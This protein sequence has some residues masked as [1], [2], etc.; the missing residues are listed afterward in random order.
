MQETL[1]WMRGHH[2]SL[3]AM[4]E[5]LGWMRGHHRR[6]AVKEDALAWMRAQQGAMGHQIEELVS[7]MTGEPA[8]LVQT[9]HLQ[10][11]KGSRAY[12]LPATLKRDLH[13]AEL[14]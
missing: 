1:A 2:G 14:Q 6:L 11:H 10:Q 4:Q 13:D 12:W 5:T 3:A 8:Q 7:L 9:P